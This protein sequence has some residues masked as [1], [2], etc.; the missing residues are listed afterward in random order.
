MAKTKPKGRK[1]GRTRQNPTPK[2]RWKAIFLAALS[3]SP[4]VTAAARQARKNRQYVYEVR[5]ADPDFKRA[6]DDAI[7]QSMDMLDGEMYRRAFEGTTKPVFYQGV[8]CGGI[9]E[10]SDGLAMF[11]AKAHRPEKYREQ[12]DLR[13]TGKDVDAAIAAELARVAGPKETEDAG[14]AAPDA[15]ADS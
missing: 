11:M 7:E 8:E 6:W 15:D 3:A 2:Q 12:L 13:V 4:N 5:D 1:P 9:Q 14:A 10:F